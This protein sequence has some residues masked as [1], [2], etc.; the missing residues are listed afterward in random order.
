MRTKELTPDERYR[1][2]RACLAMEH[3]GYRVHEMRRKANKQCE[4]IRK[5]IHAENNVRYWAKLVLDGTDNCYG[6]I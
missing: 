5:D 1:I 6:C 2:A 3:L 4:M